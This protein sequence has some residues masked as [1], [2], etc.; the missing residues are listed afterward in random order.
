[1]SE[2]LVVRFKD[3]KSIQ[4]FFD[5]CRTVKEAFWRPRTV[6]SEVHARVEDILKVVNDCLKET[7]WRHTQLGS[8]K[9]GDLLICKTGLRLRRPHYKNSI[10]IIPLGAYARSAQAALEFL[11]TL[12][13]FTP[14]V[15]SLSQRARE[16]VESVF[17]ALRDVDF[18][19]VVSIPRIE[20]ELGETLV[21]TDE[22]FNLVRCR[23]K[24]EQSSFGWR[25]SSSN[26]QNTWSNF[27]PDISQIRPVM[28]L[29][30]LVLASQTPIESFLR[31]VKETREK[32]EQLLTTLDEARK[33]L[34]QKLSRYLILRRI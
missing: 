6:G 15:E 27:L 3:A 32:E 22:T 33:S 34:E 17:C 7:V 11:T 12:T 9:Q 21:P 8:L 31:K 13:D 24:I 30:F 29:T 10:S 28:F 18:P 26:G 23:S 16:R 19:H 2:D 4:N 5:T 14:N 20:V 25:V 1:M